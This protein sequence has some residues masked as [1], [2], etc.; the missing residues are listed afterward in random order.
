MPYLL[1]MVKL[2]LNYGLLIKSISPI[3]DGTKEEG[4]QSLK[5]CKSDALF[6]VFIC[7]LL[8]SALPE[9]GDHDRKPVHFYWTVN[10]ADSIGELS[11]KGF[12]E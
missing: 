2:T 12:I 1:K 7:S 8:N 3:E 5:N 9:E 10:I 11:K 6:S 4:S